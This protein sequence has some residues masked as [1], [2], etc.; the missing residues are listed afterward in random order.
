MRCGTADVHEPKF[1]LGGE[2]IPQDPIKEEV[3]IKFLKEN[4]VEIHCTN[5]IDF[6]TLETHMKSDWHWVK[7]FA[8]HSYIFLTNRIN[9]LLN[10]GYKLSV[11]VYDNNYNE[12]IDD[13]PVSQMIV[14]LYHNL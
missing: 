8:Y 7:D 6:E 9:K 14:G 5:E 10:E 2:R 12:I 11:I 13:K 3:M 1:H 4:N